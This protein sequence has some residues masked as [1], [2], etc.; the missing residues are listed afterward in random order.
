MAILANIALMGSQQKEN[1]VTLPCSGIGNLQ[2]CKAQ[3]GV[4]TPKVLFS[5][6]NIFFMILN[7]ARFG[8]FMNLFASSNLPWKF[9]SSTLSRSC[10]NFL[11]KNTFWGVI[12]APNF[13][14]H[15]FCSCSTQRS[16]LNTRRLNA[17]FHPAN[18]GVKYFG[19]TPKLEELAILQG[20]AFLWTHLLAQISLEC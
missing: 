17:K 12:F 16:S 18:F 4:Y 9:I 7:F 14:F 11:V 20:Y 13:T 15:Q 3:E 6:P 8:L 5:F 19:V 1:P 10:F 2:C